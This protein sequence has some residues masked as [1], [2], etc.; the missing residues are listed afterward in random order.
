MPNDAIRKQKKI[1]KLLVYRTTGSLEK[2]KCHMFKT[3]E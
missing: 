1:Q 3:Y 2:K